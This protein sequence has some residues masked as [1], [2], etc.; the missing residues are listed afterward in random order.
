V[1]ALEQAVKVVIVILDQ[2]Q[3]QVAAPAEHGIQLLPE[4]QVEMVVVVAIRRPTVVD[5]EYRA[6]QE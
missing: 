1:A 4:D 6:D 5:L 3:Q 2:L